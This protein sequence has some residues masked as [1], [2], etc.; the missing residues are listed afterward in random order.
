MTDSTPPPPHSPTK[1]E[2][3]SA[4]V[5]EIRAQ[6]AEPSITPKWYE[7]LKDLLARFTNDPEKFPPE[8]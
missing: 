2:I 4:L 6:M 8:C 7:T 1:N 3:E 5:A